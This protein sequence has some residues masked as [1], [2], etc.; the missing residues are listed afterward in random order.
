VSGERRAASRIFVAGA[1]ALAAVAVVARLRGT[2]IPGWHAE[3]HFGPFPN[4]NQTANFFALAALLG[5]ALTRRE[6]RAGRW[7]QGV[8]WALAVAV[9]AQAIFLTYSRAGVAML[10]GG[11]G[12]FALWTTLRP[13]PSRGS[14]STFAGGS[15]SSGNYL[16]SRLPRAALAV[17]L[18][19]LLLSA[20]FLFGGKTLERFRPTAGQSVQGAATTALTGDFRWRIQADAFAMDRV[21]PSCG[22]GIGNFA[23]VFPLYR[24]RST[25]V[26]SRA[27]HPE[28]DW[29]WLWA[30]MGWP[31]VVAVAVG[32]GLLVRRL[33]PWQLLTG[34]EARARPTER[35]TP[36]DGNDTETGLLAE[37][38]GLPRSASSPAPDRSL[39]V[40]ALLA[41]LAFVC[42]SFVDVGAHR[43]GTQLAAVFVLGLALPVGARQPSSGWVAALFR[44]AGLLLML[45]G[46]GWFV[47]ARTGGIWPG[48]IGVENL[49]AR[50][51]EASERGDLAAVKTWTTRALDIAP[52][53]FQMLHT[54][55]LAGAYAG[56]DEAA[57]AA[58]AEDFRRARALEPLFQEFP[59]RE[60]QAWLAGGNGVHAERA[61][62][63]IEETFRLDPVRG[64]RIFHQALL[65][66]STL[67]E[68]KGMEV[69]E[70]L[71]A[72]AKQVPALLF[73][74]L[75]DLGPQDAGPRLAAVLA[76]DPELTRFD[77]AGKGEFLRI[78]A[79]HGEEN[80]EAFLA[81]MEAHPD[82]Q[83]LAWRAWAGALA[84][85]GEPKRACTL[86]ERF[87]TTPK[88]PPALSRKGAPS[89]TGEARSLEELQ[90][91]FAG[92]GGGLAPGLEL[93]RAQLDAGSRKAA[94]ATLHELEARP[95]PP[96][97]L[98]YLE[99][100]LH[101]EAQ[102]WPHAW[103][104]W[105][106]YLGRP[107]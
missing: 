37:F 68:P 89:S 35:G 98:F 31:S 82:W 27:L 50:A 105:D 52:L 101:A 26:F 62:P 74:F 94:L 45:V 32:L 92:P 16:R 100:Q 40:A 58:A 4:R 77:A 23:A 95:A 36:D 53:D 91:L 87:A 5:L 22:L 81:A 15:L 86:A 69:R 93:L 67:P 47:A 38:R 2:E 28:S 107:R 79:T 11:V 65:A 49:Q 48:R 71:E 70:S 60:A 72:L 30:E 19:L 24:E 43:L 41:L 97:Y 54:R 51:I 46:A 33:R 99:A 44:G 1:A 59:L 73:A 96:P 39:R 84:Q 61:V 9:L 56:G 75:D 13:R 66:A 64:E 34:G 17:S 12:L 78:W 6:F 18:G 57:A 76:A 25:D 102:D 55:G 106:H 85:A 80:P 104:A 29:L 3:Y 83:P 14:D 88:L 63:A 8:G 10:F 7:V 103:T 90:R 21:L 20:F 42:H